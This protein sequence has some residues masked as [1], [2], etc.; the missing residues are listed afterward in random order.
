MNHVNKTTRIGIGDPGAAHITCLIKGGYM[1]ATKVL[2]LAD[3]NITDTGAGYLAGSFKSEGNK[4]NVLH[5]AGNN[6]TKTGEGYLIKALDSISQNLKIVLEEVK[7]FSKDALKVAIKGMLFVAKNNG[8]S[9]KEMMTN[10]ETIEYCKK[11][12]LNVIGNISWGFVKCFTNA[13]KPIALYEMDFQ[14]LG[15]TVLTNLI[16]PLKKPM[17]FYCITEN[18]FSSVVDEDFA[19]CLSG[20][21]SMLND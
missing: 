19:N 20:L 12:G 15:T 7:G 18:T 11:G 21:D 6:I 16:N 5:L 8:I 10:D 9:T 1:P 13:D 14:F 3:N 2:N 17:Q 4:L